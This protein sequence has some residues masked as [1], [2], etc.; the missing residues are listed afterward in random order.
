MPIRLPHVPAGLA[1]LVG[2]VAIVA[3]VVWLARIVRALRAGERAVLPGALFVASHVAITWVGYLGTSELT[4]GWLA[5]NVWHNLQYLVFVW[6]LHAKQLGARPDPSLPL[7]SWLSQ[8]R[9]WPVY[10]LGCLAAGGAFYALLGQVRVPSLDPVLPVV[11]VTHLAVNFHHYAVDAV[12]WRTK[13]TT[14]ARA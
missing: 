7:L 2:A 3:L 10:A 4:A 6:A 14:P 9:R 12:I 11:L 13:R 1:S 8:P 5:L